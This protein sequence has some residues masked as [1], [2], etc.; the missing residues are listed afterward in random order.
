MNWVW[1]VLILVGVLMLLICLLPVQVKLRYSREG[2]DDHLLVQIIT[3]FGLFKYTVEIPVMKIVMNR[4]KK[5][6]I[7]SELETGF[8]EEANQQRIGLSVTLRKIRKII[9]VQN[10]LTEHLFRFTS[11]VRKM[12]KVFR[13]TDIKWKTE[14]G[15]GDAA[16][17]GTAAG[18]VWSAKGMVI[19]IMSHYFSLRTKPRLIVQPDF[20]ELKLS[21]SVD[22]IIRFWVGQAIVAGIQ[23][24]FY[25]LREG[26]KTW[27]IIRSRV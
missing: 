16:M 7:N 24:A 14:L 18:V 10:E 8:G 6:K 20:H 23:M 4:N 5:V 11:R 13:I 1:T 19:G 12:T 3:L 15:T 26:K 22:C 25:L 9:R 2:E 21:T 17:T 27:Q